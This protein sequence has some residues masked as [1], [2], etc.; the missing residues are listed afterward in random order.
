[1]NAHSQKSLQ[2]LMKNEEYKSKRQVNR[3]R[4]AKELWENKD[5]RIRVEVPKTKKRKKLRPV[6]ILNLDIDELDNLQDD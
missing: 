2:T 6:D 1:M 4:H 5:Y 3:N